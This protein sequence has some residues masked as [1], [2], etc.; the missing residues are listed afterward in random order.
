MSVAPFDVKGASPMG[1]G[2]TQ[3][4]TRFRGTPKRSARE[5]AMA[6]SRFGERSSEVCEA[7]GLKDTENSEAAEARNVALTSHLNR[8]HA[9]ARR[10][11]RALVYTERPNQES[12]ASADEV[13]SHCDVREASETAPRFQAAGTASA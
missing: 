12:A 5:W 8:G 10:L 2:A 3:A 11:R 6:L 7:A 1:C 4:V 13:V 9:S